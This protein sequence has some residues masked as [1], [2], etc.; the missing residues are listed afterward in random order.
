MLVIENKVRINNTV[1]ETVLISQN[2]LDEDHEL[3]AKTPEFI[4]SPFWRL[5][6]QK[7]RYQQD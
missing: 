1:K 2:C 5:E 6:V 7:S 3:G 4:F